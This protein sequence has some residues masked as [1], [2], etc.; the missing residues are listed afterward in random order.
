MARQRAQEKLCAA[1]AELERRVEVRTHE[2]AAANAELLA[3]IAERVRAEQQLIHQ[4]TH[5]SLTGLPNRSQL[6]ARL[7]AAIERARDGDG[8]SFSVLFLDLDR[9][10]LVND[11]I[12]HAAGDELLVEVDRRIAATVRYN[13]V[14]SRLGVT[15][16]RSSS[17]TPIA[18]TSRASWP[19]AS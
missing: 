3:Q 8:L 11:S 2:L 1:H 5:D 6:L 9:F 10:K 13:D 15:S 14:V 7:S 18:W 19:S 12:G 4:A 16:S 17:I